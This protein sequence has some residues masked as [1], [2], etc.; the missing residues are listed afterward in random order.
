MTLALTSYDFS[1]LQ[2]LIETCSTLSIK[3]AGC[4]LDKFKKFFKWFSFLGFNK[5]LQIELG[6]TSQ[7]NISISPTCSHEMLVL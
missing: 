3:I 4:S 2:E 7:S 6:H 5:F 1:I